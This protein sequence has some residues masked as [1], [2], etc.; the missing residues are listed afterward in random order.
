M[1]TITPMKEWMTQSSDGLRSSI[2]TLAK[3]EYT[4]KSSTVLSSDVT[5][6]IPAA[7]LFLLLTFQKLP[8]IWIISK[9]KQS[10]LFLLS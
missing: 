1:L 9:S 7:A 10:Q 6:K 2:Q 3:L 4:V 8:P 5:L